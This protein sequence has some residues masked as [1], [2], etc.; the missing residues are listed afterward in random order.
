MSANASARWGH[1]EDLRPDQ[2][3]EIVDARPIAWWPLGLLEHHGYALPAGFDGVKAK[4]FCERIAAK[5]G[6]VVLPVMWW[7][8]DGGH[9][10]FK[11]TLYQP[12]DVGEKVLDTTVRKLITF[13]FRA[14]IVYAGHYPWQGVMDRVL[15]PIAGEHP[16][17]LLRWGFEGTLGGKDLDIPGDHA[18]RWEVSYGLALLPDLVDTGA[19]RPHS[20][21]EAAKAWPTSGP[22]PAAQQF[23]GITFD[24]KN[25]LFAQ[26]GEDPR[27]TASAAAGEAQMKKLEDRLLSLISAHLA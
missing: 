19:L 23:K 11:W 21:A 25:P 4:R 22:P 13:G 7:G 10:D 5:A 24:A 20:E 8:A 17:V 12:R 16:D 14:I 2:L 18:S 26:Y 9:G 1:F 6:G 3:Q 27:A 15:A